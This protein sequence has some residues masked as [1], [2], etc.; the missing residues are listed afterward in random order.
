MT[1]LHKNQGTCARSTQVELAP[2]GTIL[3]CH[4]EGGCSGNIQGMERMVEGQKA[5]DVIGRLAGIRCGSKATSCP[6][7]LAHAL[8][9][10]LAQ[11]KNG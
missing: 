4:V 5:Q 8:Q 9:E 7:Q 3:S 2:D 1:Y 11:M 10:A 6:D